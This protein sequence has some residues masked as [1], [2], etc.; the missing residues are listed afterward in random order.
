MHP[1]YPIESEGSLRTTYRPF[2]NTKH[3]MPLKEETR[4]EL[5]Y[6]L[7]CITANDWDSY[8][9]HDFNGRSTDYSLRRNVMSLRRAR[10]LLDGLIRGIVMIRQTPVVPKAQRDLLLYDLLIPANKL[11]Y[12]TFATPLL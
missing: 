10:C 7:G 3:T 12:A 11:Y 2:Q 4:G 1:C 6:D 9:F 5:F 8:W